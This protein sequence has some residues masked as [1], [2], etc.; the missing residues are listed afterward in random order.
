M[1]EAGHQPPA[2]GL[3]T[4][5]NL[6][7][8]AEEG[9]ILPFFQATSSCAVRTW[10]NQ[11]LQVHS[12]LLCLLLLCAVQDDE[13]GAPEAPPVALGGS[14]TTPFSFPRPSG[15]AGGAPPAG[16]ETPRLQRPAFGAQPS[17]APASAAAGGAGASGE[18]PQAGPGAFS[19]PK[20][21]TPAGAAGTGADSGGVGVPGAAFGAGQSASVG[22]DTGTRVGT[23]GGFSFG[24]QPGKGSEGVGFSFKPASPEAGADA[25]RKHF[26]LVCHLKLRIVYRILV[27]EA[28]I[29]IV[30]THN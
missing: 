14:S 11:P 8:Y 15:A 19:F 4:Y 5:G 21:Q 22:G 2:G 25:A 17:A 24:G 27:S 9:R 26:T 28:S 23:P 3:A 1:P 18:K 29:W 20:P 7:Q 6:L 30:D 10:R 16:T 13:A 12:P